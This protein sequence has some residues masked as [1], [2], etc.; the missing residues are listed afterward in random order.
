MRAVSLLL[1]LVAC[2]GG[3][4][5][6]TDGVP[7]DGVTTPIDTDLC[8]EIPNYDLTTMTCDQLTNAFLNSVDGAASCNGP[9]DC[10]VVSP[11][12]TTWN[13][14]GCYYASNT[15]FG[16]AEV[17]AFNAEATNCTQDDQCSC[18]ATPEV[19]CIAGKCTLLDAP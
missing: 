13:G 15:C 6:A 18:G 19:D 12:C 11:N 8:D 1:L 4:D 7:T 3:D 9:E 17:Q 2:G 10:Q 14:V 5:D 16:S